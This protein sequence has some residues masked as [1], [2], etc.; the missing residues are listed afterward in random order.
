MLLD[1]AI[2]LATPLTNGEINETLRQ[3]APLSDDRLLL[4]NIF[5]RNLP[6]QC[7]SSVFQFANY[8]TL[9]TEDPSLSVVA[10]NLMVSFQAV[11]KF[12]DSHGLKINSEKTKLI[13]FKKPGK[14]IPDDFHLTLDN[15]V[16]KPEKTVKLLRVNL[17]QHLTFGL[18]IEN[19]VS[20]PV[21]VRHRPI[22]TAYFDT[23]T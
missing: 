18:H 3:L 23:D 5:V 2:K 11:K 14:S 21:N 10:D 8:T 6:W 22:S 13:L 17:D 16:M 20:R 19:V 12:R 4:F 9:A 7:T 1:D 15:C